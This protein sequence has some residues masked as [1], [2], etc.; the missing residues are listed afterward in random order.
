MGAVVVAF[1][2]GQRRAW[3]NFH[4]GLHAMFSRLREGKETVGKH[5]CLCPFAYL[6]VDLDLLHAGRMG[7]AE[8]HVDRLSDL[9]ACFNNQFSHDGVRCFLQVHAEAGNGSMAQLRPSGG[10]VSA[11]QART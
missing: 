6:H 10:C 9:R 2:V 4:N 5:P 7:Q 11:R 8:T 3:S 1:G